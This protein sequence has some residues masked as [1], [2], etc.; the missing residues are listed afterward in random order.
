MIKTHPPYLFDDSA[1]VHHDAIISY[2]AE[3]MGDEHDAQA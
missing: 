3:V 1:G 2:N